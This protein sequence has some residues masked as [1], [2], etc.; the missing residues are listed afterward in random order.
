[1]LFVVLGCI[2]AVILGANVVVS[3]SLT[4]WLPF[5][6]IIAVAVLFSLKAYL[7]LLVIAFC[8][9]TDRGSL[10]MGFGYWEMLVLASASLLAG[11]LIFRNRV[12]LQLQSK[13]S[14]VFFSL[15]FSI[16]IVHFLLGKL[17]YGNAAGMRLSIMIASALLF[18]WLLSQDITQLQKPALLPFLALLPGLWGVFSDLTTLFLPSISPIINAIYPSMDAMASLAGGFERLRLRSSQNLGLG[19]ICLVLPYLLCARTR[20]KQWVLPLFALSTAIALLLIFASGWRSFLISAICLIVLASFL[21]SK[22]FLLMMFVSGGLFVFGLIYYQSNVGNLP[23][24]LQRTMTWLPGDW[25]RNVVDESSGST[26]YRLQLWAKW[27]DNYFPHLWL[28]GRGQMGSEDDATSSSYHLRLI[29]AAMP[30]EHTRYYYQNLSVDMYL[31]AQ[32]MHN[33]FISSL[34]YTGV[35]GLALFLLAF[36]RCLWTCLWLL[37]R[38]H[39]LEPWQLWAVFFFLGQIPPFVFMSFLVPFIA[40]FACFVT[41]IEI[42]RQQVATSTRLAAAAGKPQVGGLPAAPPV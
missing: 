8:L 25:D 16:V 34:D 17:G 24:A 9:M 26:D 21:R 37:R 13:L 32:I 28:M 38:C 10:L 36:I 40:P 19:I 29:M 23:H 20:H 4:A 12:P 3:G 2:F 35:V 14:L 11:D 41:L 33:G 39:L 27:W 5:F 42:I 6:A 30:T 31:E 1:M 15:S 18:S 7:P 22:A